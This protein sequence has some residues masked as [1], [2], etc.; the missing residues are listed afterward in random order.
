MGQEVALIGLCIRVCAHHAVLCLLSMSFVWPR[1]RSTFLPS[2]SGLRPEQSPEAIPI[3]TTSP[4]TSP[5][6]IRSA[7][8]LEAYSISCSPTL[9]LGIDRPPLPGAEGV[10]Q[11][12]TSRLCIGCSGCASLWI[13]VSSSPERFH[14]ASTRGGNGTWPKGSRR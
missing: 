9:E 3:Q 1:A 14:W 2:H 8:Y 5:G 4:G 11:A 10:L 7:L 13:K 12:F 6:P